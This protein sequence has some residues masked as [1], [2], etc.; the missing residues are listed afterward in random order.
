MNEN[1][2]KLLTGIWNWVCA[3]EKCICSYALIETWKFSATRY[4]ERQRTKGSKSEKRAIV[5]WQG[6]RSE[7]CVRVPIIVVPV[8]VILEPCVCSHGWLPPYIPFYGS[9]R[10]IKLFIRE[11]EKAIKRAFDLCLF[12][13]D[14][15]F[16]FIF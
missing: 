4:K 8:P 3:K 12:D 15:P 11:R 1:K 14:F 2:Q 5:F 9:Q 16:S 13:H 10:D 7:W 6:R